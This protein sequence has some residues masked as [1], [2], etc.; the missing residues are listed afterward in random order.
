MRRD[1]NG[2]GEG[3][4][5]DDVGGERDVSRRIQISAV[6]CKMEAAA[7][8]DRVRKRL[9][10]LTRRA[11]LR[12]E[13]PMDRISI[14]KNDEAARRLVEDVMREFLVRERWPVAM[15]VRG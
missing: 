5:V 1:A 3:R 2:G 6:T 4:D 8:T 10:E 13:T 9:T 15:P 11:M 12:C 7:E 14:E